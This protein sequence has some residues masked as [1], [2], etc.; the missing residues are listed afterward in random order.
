MADPHLS[1]HAY[2]VIAT[3]ERYRDAQRA[4]DHLSDE[5][6]PVQHVRIVGRDLEFVEQITGRRNY[7]V[8]AADSAGRGALVGAL[9]GF[10]FGLFS[11]VDP[12][13]ASWLLAL[14]GVVLGAVIGAALGLITHALTRGRRDFSSVES[15]QASR[16]DVL[17]DEAVADEASR[18]LG[19]EAGG[20]RRTG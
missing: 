11:L 8:A 14:W 17:V 16:Y 15:M 19:L 10:I 4:V 1:G 7:G 5:G 2:R 12:L 6:F 13:V 3:Y 18:T 20:S 9:L